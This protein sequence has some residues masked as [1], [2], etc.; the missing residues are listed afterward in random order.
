MSVILTTG[1]APCFIVVESFDTDVTREVAEG[2][3]LIFNLFEVEKDIVMVTLELSS[4]TFQVQHPSFGVDIWKPDMHDI[5]EIEKALLR[6]FGCNFM[7][8]GKLSDK[9]R[10]VNTTIDLPRKVDTPINRAY[11]T[12]SFLSQLF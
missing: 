6:T 9:L 1:R 7:F 2:K 10:L 5:K 4:R 11:P 12:Q 8:R 3:K